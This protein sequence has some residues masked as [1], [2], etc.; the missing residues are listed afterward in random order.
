MANHN[1]DR[2]RFLKS[3][4]GVV[5][6][7][8]GF[9]S[10]AS[11][12]ALG[13]GLK[14]SPSNRITIGF[15]GVG[16]RGMSNMNRVLSKTDAQIV[17]VCDVDARHRKRAKAKVDS[18]YGNSD[19]QTYDDFRKL[20]SRSDIDAI[21]SSL[22]DHWLSIVGV[23]AAAQGKHIYSEKPLAY[24]IAEGRAICE[25][26]DRYNIVWQTGSQQRSDKK[27]RTAAELVRNGR[28]GKVN[29]VRVVL[30]SGILNGRT[31]DTSLAEVPD[32]FD[33]NMWLGP[34]PRA[35]YSP[36]RC[37]R[38]YRWISDY[39]HGQISDWSGH[40]C[41][42]AQW[43]MGT[44][45]TGPVEVK[46]H[47]VRADGDGGLYNTFVRYH[48][49]CK[50]PQGFTMIV[51]DA[52]EAV[53]EKDGIELPGS[54]LDAKLGVLF[55]GTDGWIHVNRSGLT[56]YPES[57]LDEPIGKDGIHLYESNDHDQ[58]FLD[59]VKTGRQTAAPA[60]VA[61]RSNSIGYLG[62]IA[63]E[64]GR[65]LQWNPQKEQFIDDSMA[66]RLLS[67]PMRSPWRL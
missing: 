4:G 15:I 14:P 46:G 30:P 67:R 6:G 13:K 62:I 18:T 7:A 54:F 59:C 42:I 34:A 5:L 65:K 37:H 35:P 10:I 47:G 39:A 53:R 24:S 61:H 33:Y 26:V 27:F 36:G 38:E 50:F 56:A 40:H 49:E 19:C 45:R 66:N 17:G 20:I 60:E 22:P 21:Y 2:R 57:I 43:A 28:I 58:N 16:N 63:M 32:G 23:H 3:S 25:A 41:D 1:V 12:A 8:L 52:S 55:E 29:V 31:V 9:P 11:A 48:F 44:E 64:L 51:T